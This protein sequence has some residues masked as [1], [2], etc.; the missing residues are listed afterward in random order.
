MIATVLVTSSPIAI[1]RLGRELERLPDIKLCGHA[2]DLSGAY[3]L[4][5]Q[6]EPKLVILGPELLRHPDFS[7]LLAMFR[8]MG[9]T[10]M[11]LPSDPVPPGPAAAAPVL[12]TGLTGD[13]LMQAI[14]AALARPAAPFVPPGLAARPSAPPAALTGLTS[15]PAR[16]DRFILIGSSTGGIDA[17]L[18][19]LSVF[20][21]DCPPTAIVQHTGQAF[22]DSLLRLLVRS[23]AAQ[24]VP[25]QAGAVL[26]PGMVVVGA[27][28]GG[29]LRLQPGTPPRVQV[30]PGAPVSGHVPSVDEMFRSAVPFAPRVT[31]ALLTGMGRDGAQGMLELRKGGANTIAQ[32]EATSVVYGMPRAAWEIGA[33]QVRLPLDR[34]GPELLA[35]CAD[36]RSTVAG[37]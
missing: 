15:A 29:H 2:G 26:K 14:T 13:H 37:Q 32:D 25:A 16:P 34:I 9:I 17:L 36:R 35:R 20:P 24:V 28:C 33:A 30:T 8:V 7:G 6:T 11:R 19:V 31:A 5:E 12:D 21:A 4:V 23:C 22:S 10:W 18:R 1:S 3:V 27:G